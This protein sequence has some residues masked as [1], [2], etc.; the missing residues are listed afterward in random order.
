MCNTVEPVV[1]LTSGGDIAGMKTHNWDRG[2]HHHRCLRRHH[3]HLRNYNSNNHIIMF[4]V[5]FV[6]IIIIVI[7]ANV[8]ICIKTV[9][10]LLQAQF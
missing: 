9:L 7:I 6:I 4:I 3:H 8:C 5:I 10:L 2:F 1:Q